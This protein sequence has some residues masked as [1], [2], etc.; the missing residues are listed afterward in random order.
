MGNYQ[1]FFAHV[2]ELPAVVNRR[3]NI[4]SRSSRNQRG[5]G[6]GM[7]FCSLVFEKVFGLQSSP[8]Y[9]QPR[10]HTKSTQ[11]LK[12]P[13]VV[14]PFASLLLYSLT[15]VP[16]AEEAAGFPG[17]TSVKCSNFAW[18]TRPH[19]LRRSWLRLQR[20]AS[21]QFLGEGGFVA[22]DVAGLDAEA[23]S[24]AASS[25]LYLESA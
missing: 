23:V 12:P 16:S 20:S 9:C 3:F 21:C 15:V 7:L 19:R 10:I 25:E 17:E 4:P 14:S 11:I 5:Q 13:A 24:L 2:V 22:V 8:R 18:F 6:K 1:V